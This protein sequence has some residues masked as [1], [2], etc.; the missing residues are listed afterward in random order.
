[1]ST[2]VFMILGMIFFFSPWIFSRKMATGEISLL[3]LNVQVFLGTHLN[4]NISESVVK[5]ATTHKWTEEKA[6]PPEVPKECVASE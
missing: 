3:V 6:F 2:F 5:M 1:M 4:I